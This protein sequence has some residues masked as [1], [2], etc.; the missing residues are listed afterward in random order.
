M[1]GT[2]LVHKW[3]ELLPSKNFRHRLEV[4]Y[5]D[6]SQQLEVG[7]GLNEYT[8]DGLCVCIW[9]EIREAFKVRVVD[10]HS[11]NLE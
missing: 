11:V 9:Q 10:K 8:E 4:G 5:G 1:A 6:V 2:D 7:T 3:S